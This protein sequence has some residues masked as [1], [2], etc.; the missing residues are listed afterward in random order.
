MDVSV[1]HRPQHSMPGIRR[2]SAPRVLFDIPAATAPLWGGIEEHVCVLGRHMI[3]R[4][5][6][7]LFLLRADYPPETRDRLMRAGIRCVGGAA[8]TAFANQR[9]PLRQ[10][11]ASLRSLLVE[12]QVDVVHIHSSLH[13]SELWS[14]LTARLAGV[15]AI[16]CTYHC[17]LGPES[18][19]RRVGMWGMHRLLGVRGIGVSRAV[20]QM[21][22]DRYWL[23]CAACAC[24]PNGID[25]PSQHMPQVRDPQQ[26]AL[27][28]AVVSRLSYEKGV[29]VFISAL[30]HVDAT[31]DIQ[32]AVIGEGDELDRL[33]AQAADLG[34]ADRVE[35]RGFVPGAA[36]LLRSF[37]LVAIPSRTEGF[38][39]LAAEA[40]AAGLPVVASGVGGL[41]DL[42]RDGENG[43]LVPSDDAV[44]FARA[45]EAAARDRA[46][47][48]RMGAAARRFFERGLRA[49]VM[50]DRTVEI[51]AD[52][53]K[54]HALARTDASFGAALAGK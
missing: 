19:Q 27:R 43:W 32:A 18:S 29:D 9:P 48:R 2:T 3:A 15:R 47:C 1:A 14:A 11:M 39:L 53:L 5:F 10:W 13:G 40:F 51:Y 46:L 8:I 28:V 6:E 36:E 35:F 21:V 12:E 30:A 4:G 26:R 52:L 16:V 23:P 24:V 17:L 45:I 54:L 31:L 7:P 33:K 38:G 25:E 42:V 22:C 49:E 34:I 37:D 20:R 50:V 44:A 41:L